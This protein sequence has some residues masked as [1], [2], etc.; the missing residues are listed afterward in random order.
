VSCSVTAFCRMIKLYVTVELKTSM[1]FF[2]KI[3]I[4]YVASKRIIQLYYALLQYHQLQNRKF[5][6]IEELISKCIRFVFN[7]VRYNGN[8]RIVD[9]CKVC[10]R[11][12]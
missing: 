7:F 5:N 4:N 8:F 3:H 2:Y 1:T 11:V 10:Y 12:T 6:V 9:L